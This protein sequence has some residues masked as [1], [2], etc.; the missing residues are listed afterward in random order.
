MQVG[1]FVA[2][3]VAVLVNS[4]C[5]KTGKFPH[6]PH[7]YSP[8]WIKNVFNETW[9]I[10]GFKYFI[11]PSCVCK[12]LLNSKGGG[13]CA[14]SSSHFSDQ[15]YCYV[16][17]PS[18]CKDLME[19]NSILGEK[20]SAEACNN[21]EKDLQISMISMIK[22]HYLCYHLFIIWFSLNEFTLLIT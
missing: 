14:K 3:V 17:I 21:G 11:V 18:N 8:N 22:I 12:N 20:M 10:I 5:T 13:N 1:V 7:L 19:S 6:M 9:N 16:Q 4:G 15:R 2:T